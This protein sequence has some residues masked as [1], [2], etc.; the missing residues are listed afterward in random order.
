MFFFLATTNITCNF[1]N[2]FCGYIPNSKFVRQTGPSPSKSSG[3]NSDHTTQEGYYGLC[4]GLLLVNV[5]DT[6]TLSQNLT[7]STKNTK[8]SFWYYMN[9]QQIGFLSLFAN[10]SLLWSLEGRQDDE[11]LKA[12]V[13]L[14]I[15][16]Y[17]VGFTFLIFYHM[18]QFVF[19]LT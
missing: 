16:T 9:G 14:P 13:F 1:E 17:I 3:P 6:C 5:N 2:G 11:W 15:G 4:N 12:E 19:N 7:V 10:D 8:F 18:D